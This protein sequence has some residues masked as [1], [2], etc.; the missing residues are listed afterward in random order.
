MREWGGEL[1]PQPL[2]YHNAAHDRVLKVRVRVR[3]RVKGLKGEGD[4]GEGWR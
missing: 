4:G 1:V 2:F 3:V